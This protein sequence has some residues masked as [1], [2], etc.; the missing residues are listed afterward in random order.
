L[1]KNNEPQ[2]NLDDL[3]DSALRGYTA[4][5]SRPG[6]EARI[7]AHLADEPARRPAW[8][9]WMKIGAVATA[10][11]TVLLLFMLR[12]PQQST[13]QNIA[14]VQREMP[15]QL[16][17]APE[18]TQA[19]LGANPRV[20]LMARRGAFG[21]ARREAWLAYLRT[22]G[23]QSSAHLTESTD[24]PIEIKPSAYN[25]IVIEPIKINPI[26]N[27]PAETGDTL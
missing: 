22:C 17:S 23:P 3:I 27:N 7:L 13:P 24:E 19:E 16:I 2:S 11:A 25:P 15:P 10:V 5:A 12:L 18:V 1:S 4:D 14:T 8:I 26:E 20:L 21:S 9:S 6:L